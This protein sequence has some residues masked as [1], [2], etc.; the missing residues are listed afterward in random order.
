M[1]LDPSTGLPAT[2]FTSELT[3]EARALADVLSQLD[4]VHA[5]RI[6]LGS[7]IG[8][9]EIVV[10]YILLGRREEDWVGVMGLGVWSDE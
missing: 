10:L 7:N 6:S 3:P 5:F 2:L 4:D 9:T 1:N 8:R